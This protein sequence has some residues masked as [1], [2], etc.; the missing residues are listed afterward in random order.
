[1]RIAVMADA[2]AN[3]PALQAALAAIAVDGVDAIYHLG[4]AIAIGPYPREC[5]ELLCTTPHMYCLTGNH[6]EWYARGL[7]ADWRVM[8]DASEHEH[9][10]W[11]HAQLGPTWRATVAQWPDRL[12]LDWGSRLLLTHYARRA[13][14]GFADVLRQP[15]VA[16]LDALFADEAEWVLF[17]HAHAACDLQG[18]RR[19][20]CPGSLGCHNRASARYL[21][22]WI[23]DGQVRVEPRQVE[24]DDAPLLAALEDR[25]VPA[26][27]FIRNVFFRRDGSAK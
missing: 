3:L 7:P 16:A 25:R 1:M 26:R 10:L 8:M 23:E 4:D 12:V 2:H 21:L 9:Q 17:G 5:L 6:D 11:T 22:L 15:S 19:Y 27:E 20:L 13:G 18:Q 24:Y 14:G